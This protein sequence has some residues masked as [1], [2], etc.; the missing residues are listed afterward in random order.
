MG[1]AGGEVRSRTR[2]P[3]PAQFSSGSSCLSHAVPSP[4]R[5]VGSAG[6][7]DVAL[8]VVCESSSWGQP[9]PLPVSVHAGFLMPATLTRRPKIGLPVRSTNCT[10][11][12]ET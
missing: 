1:R 3:G 8:F 6:L 10:P 11:G 9:G 7:V 12:V 4:E 2:L 5:V